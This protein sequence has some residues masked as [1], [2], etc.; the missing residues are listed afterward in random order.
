MTL[1]HLFCFLVV[2]LK[3]SVTCRI[4]NKDTRN[5]VSVEL[6]FTLNIWNM[7]VCF[8]AKGF[9]AINVC[10][11]IIQLFIMCNILWKCGWTSISYVAS[12]RNSFSSKF[13]Q[14]LSVMQDW[15][16]VWFIRSAI[17]LCREKW[18]MVGSCWILWLLQKSSKLF[19]VV[20]RL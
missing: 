10:F 12:S 8:T 20:I 6:A 2:E 11:L 18:G 5:Q 7:N 19:T 9:Q 4:P 16:R 3:L 1:E 17:P 13:K 15:L 14:F